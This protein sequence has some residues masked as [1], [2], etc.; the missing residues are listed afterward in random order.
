MVGEAG[1]GVEAV[2]LARRLRPDVV[3]MDIRMPS[4]DGVEADP[5]DHGRRARAQVLMLTTFDL[6]E[7]VYG[8]SRRCQ[9]LPAQG[10]PARASWSAR[11]AWSP[12]AT[13]C[14]APRSPAGSRHSSP[15]AAHRPGAT[16]TLAA[17]RARAG[18]PELIARGLSNAEI[19]AQLFVSETR[20]RPTSAAC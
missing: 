17:H 15:P 18:D 6:D 20:S 5:A 3:L 8:R 4:M 16:G 13:R 9:R 10:R 7:Y 2:E 12:P 11:S 19:A 14:C 1:D